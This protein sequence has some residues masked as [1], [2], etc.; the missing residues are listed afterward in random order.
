M[1]TVSTV[2]SSSSGGSSKSSGVSAGLGTDDFLKLLVAQL[3]NQDPMNPTSGTE[4]LAQ[5]AQFTMVEKLS[6]MSVQYADLLV[7]QKV[8]QA[9]SFIGLRVSYADGSGSAVT[10]L[11]SSVRLD[12]AGPVL[13]VGGRDVV[14]SSVS[15]VSG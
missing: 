11:V 3:K 13:S 1:S 15:A 14:L 6:A 4:F 5:T 7:A 12:A 9:T 10:G 2:S 8:S